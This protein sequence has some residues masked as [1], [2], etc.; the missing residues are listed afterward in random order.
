MSK[1]PSP[2][3]GNWTQMPGF[4]TWFGPSAIGFNFDLSCAPVFKPNSDCDPV[5]E[6]KAVCDPGGLSVIEAFNGR[7]VILRSRYKFRQVISEL[8]RFRS[9]TG[10]WSRINL[11]QNDQMNVEHRWSS[12][13][14]KNRWYIKFKWV[15]TSHIK[16]SET[17]TKNRKSLIKWW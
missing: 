1:D 6:F 13:E 17:E 2:S 3:Q 7:S 4:H 11:P 12:E 14:S 5:C 15:Q 9:H 16:E 10:V 8:R